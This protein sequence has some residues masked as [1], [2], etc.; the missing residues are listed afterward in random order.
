MNPA[1]ERLCQNSPCAIGLRDSIPGNRVF[2]SEAAIG[3]D[4]FDLPEE[5][6]GENARFKHS[7]EGRYCPGVLLGTSEER[8][9][10]IDRA[11][12]DVKADLAARGL[13]RPE[14]EPDGNA[15]V[16]CAQIAK[17]LGLG[18]NSHGAIQQRLRRFREQHAEGWVE[19]NESA[20]N[21]PGFL[22]EWGKVKSC[23]QG[24]LPV[25]VASHSQE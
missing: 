11:L 5:I 15:R 17:I 9:R 4:G 7:S 19:T 24:V 12:A 10:E 20:K 1:P 22:Y 2:R 18:K 13:L 25:P 23:V 3:L 21:K 6:V 8:R 16:S 14:P